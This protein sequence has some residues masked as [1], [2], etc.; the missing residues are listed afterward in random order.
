MRTL[1][2]LYDL[3]PGARDHGLTHEEVADSL[4]R[5][6]ANRL[7]PVSREP[8]WQKFL[9]KFDE[10]IIKILL[11]ATLLKTVVDLFDSVLLG[12]A[13]LALVAL[14]LVLAS[15]FRLRAWLP[16]LMFG[17]AAVLVGLSLF[18]PHPSVEGLA[19]MLAV[20]LATGV[21]FLSE[22][23]SDREFEVLN[24]EKE[25]LR[26][27]VLRHGAVHTVPLEE[28]VVGDLI[29]LEMGDEV[30]ADGRAAR[31]T[32]LL[33]DQSLL[34][35]ESE[36]VRKLVRPD[37]DAGDG[38]DRPGCVY[39]GTQV[40]DGAGQM[41]VTEVGDLTMLGQIAR[42]LSVDD[43]ADG[44]GAARVRNKLTVSKE[45]TPLQ[46]KLTALAGSISKVGYAAAIA[47]FLALLVRGTVF[48]HEVR[49][50]PT[51]VLDPA[52]GEYQIGPRGDRETDPA[53]GPLETTGKALR[54]SLRAAIEYFVYMV[55]IV[56]V[57]VP[58]GLP[59]SVTV[60]LA[61][62]MRKMT[63]ANSLV[64][65]LVACETIGSATV[66]CSD[67]TGT[68]TENRM[69]VDRLGFGGV[70]FDRATDWPK[71]TNELQAPTD[72]MALNGAVN[73]TAYLDTRDG[74]PVV[75]GNSTEGALLRWGR[76]AGIDYTA[77]RP[78]FPHRRFSTLDDASSP[79]L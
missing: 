45:Q 43:P 20:A 18:N 54:D 39:R 65:Q 68:L 58:E 25:S 50:T 28:V 41:V 10:P 51:F 34:T 35:G 53:R 22:Y 48:T 67:K 16:A 5:F 74:K 9:D 1:R 36:P 14:V 79:P 52:T 7:T 2:E 57:A 71:P 4:T 37:D 70:V 29:V 64:R 6:G 26:A 69:Q 42:R 13:G 59:M 49:F 78:V 76:E 24:A 32:E 23:R 31:A 38:P 77:V 75:I 73:S 15:V 56:V 47:I 12:L 11:A 27:K 33:V 66:I 17:T 21:A 40:V 63:R 44:T 55:I 19:V 62:T 60:S 61:L 46:V 8:V 72:W 3:F 30:P